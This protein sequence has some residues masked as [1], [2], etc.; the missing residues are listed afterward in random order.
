MNGIIL[1]NK[2]V[3]MSSFGVVSKVRKILSTKYNQ[4]VKVG[5]AG[6]LD[7]F[8]TGLLILLSGKAT[9]NA[10]TFLKLD[11]S[12]KATM[13]LGK[14][15]STADPEGE[16]SEYNPKI[17]SLQEINDVIKTFIGYIEQTPPVYS[18]IKING[19]RAYNL[20]RKGQ[21][22]E[23]KPRMVKIH[24]IDKVDYHYPELSFEVKV[25]SGTYIRS[26]AEDIGYKLG[27]G[28]YLT[29]LER[30]SIDSYSLDSARELQDLS[31]DNIQDALL[32]LG[33]N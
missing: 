12:Y 9:K 28:A 19:Q 18:A 22:V 23:M 33:R 11:K 25:G 3:G 16:I 10:D 14:V 32:D 21:K 29:S 31:V 5:H 20:A 1:V 6:T 24:S 26:L 15:S 17:P 2:P 8:A 7:P 4:K 27:T 30:T 13:C